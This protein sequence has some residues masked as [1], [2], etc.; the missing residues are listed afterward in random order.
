MVD[1]KSIAPIK[2]VAHAWPGVGSGPLDLDVG[3]RLIFFG[4][5]V[6]SCIPRVIQFT[7]FIEMFLMRAKT[8][9]GLNVR[10]AL[11]Q[12]GKCRWTSGWGF[13]S[14]SHAPSLATNTLTRLR[15]FA[16]FKFYLNH[17]SRAHG[18]LHRN[19]VIY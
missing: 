11:Q 13:K 5:S 6:A 18:T 7:D 4:D 1:P 9:V 16:T 15:M 8:Q 10:I 19:I 14:T 2:K 17:E 3:L 12:N